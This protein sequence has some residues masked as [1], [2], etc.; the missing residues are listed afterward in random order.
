MAHPEQSSFIR[1]VLACHGQAITHASKILEV[2][3]QDI[4]GS[5]RGYFP[6]ASQKTWLGI[7]LGPAPGVDLVIP[8]ELLQLPDG[9]ADLAFSTECFEHAAAWQQILLN[10]IRC[11]ADGGLILF[12]CAGPGRPT[13]GT[14][15][16]DANASPFT[17]QYYKNLSPG[18]FL[19]A[20]EMNFYFSKFAFEVDAELGDTYFWGVRNANVAGTEYNSAEDSLARARGQLSVA[21]ERN[22]ELERQC[23]Y[24]KSH[25][26]ALG[27]E[28]AISKSG[29]LFALKL[30]RKVRSIFH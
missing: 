10:M 28:L 25:N 7:D 21:I 15:D 29:T 23:Q 2:G 8:G 6:D 20:I 24:L 12:T 18:D 14:L 27:E 19:S 26:S 5:I 4:N 22:L 11:T 30:A 1:K 13:H 3:S 9:W 16:T 17:N